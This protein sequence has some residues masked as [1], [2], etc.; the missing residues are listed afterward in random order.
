MVEAF[1]IQAPPKWIERWRGRIQENFPEVETSLLFKLPE[2]SWHLNCYWEIQ[3]DGWKEVGIALN[4]SSSPSVRQNRRAFR[5]SFDYNL[6]K[7]ID[8]TKKEDD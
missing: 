1:M 6:R 7:I 2:L 3:G 5:E 4:P 8:K